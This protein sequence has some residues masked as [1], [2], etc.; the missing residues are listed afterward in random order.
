MYRVLLS[1][2]ALSIFLSSS[3]VA[4]DDYLISDDE[5]I[6]YV[7]TQEHASLMSQ[8]KGYQE[9]IVKE[10]EKEFGFKLDDKLYVGLASNNNQ[11]ANGFSTQVPFNS[12]L[13][14]G[15][16]AIYIDYLFNYS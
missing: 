13:F 3:V 4:P 11:I 12:Q 1:L 10:Y 6:S 2:T 9:A 15:A 8:M 14:Y 7:Y 5:N 16:G